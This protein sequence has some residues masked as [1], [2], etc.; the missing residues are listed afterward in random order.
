VSPVPPPSLTERAARLGRLVETTLLCAVLGAMIMLAAAQIALRNLAGSGIPWADE[1]L[2]IM[3]L[4]V[5]LLGAVAAGRDKRHVSIDAVSRYL[6]YG[7]QRGLARWVDAIAGLACA[8]MA[9]FSWVFLADSW[10]ADDRV[11]GGAVPAWAVQVILPVAFALMAY[12]YA[13]GAV[14]PGSS[15][16]REPVGH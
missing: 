8:V 12:R 13:L 9:W 16:P 14:V 4:W 10:S 15:E 6:P 3:V 1:A 11:L 7:I 5:A 2:R